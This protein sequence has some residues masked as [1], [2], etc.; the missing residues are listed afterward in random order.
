MVVKKTYLKIILK[1]IKQSFGRFVAIF[2]IVALGVGLLSG[3]IVTTPD[4]HYSVDEYYDKHNMADIFI[5]GTMGLTDND[6]KILSSMDEIEEI[7]PAYVTDTLMENNKKE[8]IAT[9]VF[10]I[11]LLNENEGVKVNQLELIKGRLPQNNSECLVERKGGF[12]SDI[13]IGSKL[14]VSKDN[15]NY[16]DLDDMY[17]V[18]EY[19]VVGVVANTFYFSFEREVTNIGNGRLGAIIYVDDSSYDLDV[20][21]DFYITASGFKDLD[22]FS[23]EYDEGIESIVKKLKNVGEERSKV[24]FDEILTEATDKLNEGKKEYEEAK[25][26]AETELADAYNEIQEGKADLIKAWSEIQDG[27][28]ELEEAKK[29]LEEE[30][31]KAEKE[32][33][34]AKIK[35]ADALIELNDGE[36]ELKDAW[37]ELQEGELEYY[38]GYKKYLDSKKELEK[39]QKKF[40]DGEQEYLDGKKK[41]SDGKREIRQGERELSDAQAKLRD[42]QIEYD[43]G[44]KKLQGEKAQFEQGIAPYIQ[45]LNNAQL[46][47]SFSSALELFTAIDN[48]S[49]GTV[50]FAFEGVVSSAYGEVQG[51]ILQLDA[52][53]PK[54]ED[55]IAEL[56]S[57]I[58]LLEGMPEDQKPIEQIEELKIQLSELNGK[59]SYARSKKAELEAQLAQMPKSA[60]IFINGWQQIKAG[61]AKLSDAKRQI[62]DGYRQLD[63]GRAELESAWDEIDSAERELK[64]AKKELD[65]NRQKIEDGW[66]ELEEGRLELEDA[67]KKLDDGYIKHTDGR[68]ELDDGWIKYYDGLDELAEGELELKDEI[69]KAQKEIQDGEIDLNKGTREYYDGQKELS[70]GETEYIEAKAEADKELSDALKEILDAEKEIEEIETPK[71]YVLDRDYNMSYVSF[72]MNAEKVAAISKVFPVFFYLVAALVALTTMTRMVEEERTQIGTLKALGYTKSTIMFKYLFYCGLASILGSALGLFIGFK[73]LPYVIWNAFT[74]MYHL[75]RFVA[76]FN[77]RIAIVSSGLAILSTLIATIYACHNALKEKPSILM[78]PR[79][80]KAGKR[81]LLERVGFIWSRMSF[82]HKAT[83]RNLFR[84]KKHF[85]MTVIG[86]GGCTA[87]LVTGFG[88]RDSIG[89]VANIQY[90][91]IFNYDVLIELDTKDELDSSIVNILND[92]KQ[93]K[94]YLNLFINKGYGIANDERLE[95]NLFVSESLEDLNQ[96]ITLRERKTKNTFD[97]DDNSIII[98]EKLSEVLNLKIGDKITLENS[99]EEIS[100]FTITGITE[101]YLGNNVYMSNERYKN[102]FKSDN[103][104]NSILVDTPGLTPYE[105]DKMISEILSSNGVLSAE[106]VGQAKRTFDNLL[107]SINYIVIVIILASGALAFIVLYNLT[108][109]NINERKKELATLK[110]LGFH[111]E[112]VSAYIF[113]ETTILTLIGI[114]VGLFLGILLHAFI[115]DTIESTSYMFGRDVKKLSFLIS[116]I[117]TI[118][119]SLIVNIFMSKK[120]RNIQMVDSMK[121]VD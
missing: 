19:T 119:F 64:K 91:E 68:K 37:V 59:L 82:N 14:I 79:V 4:M 25:L 15:D 116:A 30:T 43:A 24:R 8:V 31:L 111:N 67:R 34:D 11:P 5:K 49:T 44:V 28:R 112:E 110:V 42:A 60:D 98:T 103:T 72:I 9:R 22:S 57:K 92:N 83:A 88:L 26:E 23:D 99:E 69:E 90:K 50:K 113:R 66:A 117:I 70:E 48:D 94:N 75:P 87:L 47:F 52:E 93:T 115:I 36:K 13:P 74:V 20:Y 86:I 21:T 39:A 10:G 102:S 77:T 53:I 2:S 108:N 62:D 89:D 63:R 55:G 33:E 41:L 80:P 118:I 40:D 76:G 105:Q 120:L 1:E 17:N 81:I 27:R 7:M 96:F 101:H 95:V 3:L 46:G 65:E 85:F 100:D 121:A 58:E 73:L 32:I 71:W 97:L 16:E 54:L 18:K 106:F 114:L 109:I 38:D 51:G 56:E 45:A 84:Y 12:L 78:L 61:E 104:P 29:T 35:L 6:I 107:I